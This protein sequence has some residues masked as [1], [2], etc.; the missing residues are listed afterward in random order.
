M[1]K[2]LLLA[3]ILVCWL[4]QNNPRALADTADENWPQWRGPVANG[5]APRANPPVAWS[6]TDGIRWKTAI[7]G[8]GSATPLIWGKKVFVLTAIPTGKTGE[9]PAEATAASEAREPGA[10]RPGGR[11]G[12]GTGGSR[13]SEVHQFALLCLDRETGKELWRRVAREEAPHEAHHQDGTLASSSPVTDGQHVWA[14]FG[15]R[16]LHC[17]DMEGNHKWSRDFGK[18]RV[19]MSFGEGSSPALHKDTII[20]NW[21]HEEDSFIAALDKA[22]GDIL[23]RKERDERTS[24][25]TPLVLGHNGQTQVIVPATRRITSYDL[26]SG[27]ILW[28]CGGLTSN[29]VPSP[30]AA[31]GVVYCMSGFR[32]NALLAIKLD[33][34][35]DISGTDAVVWRHNR[36]TPYVPS[37]ILYQDRLYFFASNNGVLSCFDANSGRPLFESQRL[38]ALQGVYAS[39]VAAAGR[40][41]LTGRNGAT[42]V[43]KCAPT[44]EVL[45]TNRLDERFDASPALA[46]G[47]LFLRGREFLYCVAE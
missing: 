30:V 29:V 5:V 9:P 35:G 34:R 24:W 3:A 15:S 19:A 8:R 17:Y 21:D 33:A 23:W 37:P 11:G 13:P 2:L 28:E 25:S 1:S 26:A 43:L 39:P 7:P 6:E 40:I 18:M 10:G 4:A 45:S 42:V 32:G 14:Y 46:G 20:V 44:L 38:D 31:N 36:A 27:E 12:R 41:Y 16:G 22:T 47:E